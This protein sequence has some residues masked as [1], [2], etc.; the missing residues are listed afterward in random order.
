MS[1]S[2]VSS[3]EPSACT[4]NM[5]QDFTVFPSR[6]TVQAPQLL[7]S[8]P[9][10]VPVS[11]SFSRMRCTSRSLGSTSTSRCRPLTLRRT[12]CF[13]AIA[14][15]PHLRRRLLP[16]AFQRAL[17]GPFCQFFHQT[18]FIFN[19]TAQV[20]AWFRFIGGEL[21]RLPDRGFVQLFALQESLCLPRLYR[22]CANIGQSDACL[23]TSALLV[24]GQLGRHRCRGKVPH[25]APNLK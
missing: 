23:L 11:A 6:T 8:Q 15:L 7:V 9:T 25:F 21:S 3:S 5:V 1:P 10:W 24:E 13:F 22:C 19:R 14:F 16:D 18:L 17:E 4:A 2:T 12:V 20:C